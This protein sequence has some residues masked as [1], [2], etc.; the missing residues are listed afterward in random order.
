MNPT[1]LGELTAMARQEVDEWLEA[2]MA[3]IAAYDPKLVAAGIPM[4]GDLFG[5]VQSRLQHGVRAKSATGAIFDLL[6]RKAGRFADMPATPA[7]PEKLGDVIGGLDRIDPGKAQAK[8]MEIMQG[9]RLPDQPGRAIPK[10]EELYVPKEIADEV[11]RIMKPF[12]APE[13]M[14]WLMK[15]FD[16]ITDLFRAHVTVP[17]PA[18]HGRNIISATL[19]NWLGGIY[20]PLTANPIA[21]LTRPTT[22]AISIIRGGNAADAEKAPYMIARRITDPAEASRK[23][24]DLYFAH[25]SGSRMRQ[26]YA[27]QMTGG[28]DIAARNVASEIPG[29][30]P[31]FMPGPLTGTIGQK[32]N[33][34]D[35]AHFAPIQIGKNVT[36]ASEEVIRF[37]GF[38]AL[39]KQGWDPAAAMKRINDLQVDYTTGGAVDKFMRRV[40]PFW[41]FGR[42]MAE[43]T[44]KELTQR[45][46]PLAGAIRAQ[47]QAASAQDKIVPEHLTRSPLIP[48]PGGLGGADKYLTATS[49]MT[50]DPMAFL[51]GGVRGALQELGSRATPYI[52]G[53]IEWALGRSL[54]QAG[55]RGGR[56]LEDMYPRV[57]GT[58]K[59]IANVFGAG[60]TEPVKIP[61][62]RGMEQI[63]ANSPITRYLSSLGV[64]F[65]EP[66]RKS[67]VDKVLRLFVG[68][69][70]SS[71]TPE[72]QEKEIL[73]RAGDL[74]RRKGLGRTLE[75]LYIPTALVETLPAAE[76]TEA[77]QWNALLNLIRR[78]RSRRAKG[79]PINQLD[80]LLG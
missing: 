18:F 59:D 23:Y 11:Q 78:N 20:D 6:G 65:E 76:Q 12:Q 62:G 54:F 1:E 73:N 32:L 42:G 36:A 37:G 72:M 27:L 29:A 15:G 52:K 10:F 16:Y 45:P 68:A 77:R 49:M 75:K 22:D 21:K 4:F 17:W 66:E 33:P 50:E 41:T 7:I 48:L 56:A 44:A 24:A 55:G 64:A 60:L 69:K 34:A 39:M 80:E 26:G 57:G 31:G 2:G 28:G 67:V 25:K 63:L 47:R 74:L 79:L 51:G 13:E 61:G 46:G 30:Q 14:G 5:A 38:I 9:N 3:K 58:L 8:V 19:Q 40:F 71:V 70:I 43:F 35:I 53:P